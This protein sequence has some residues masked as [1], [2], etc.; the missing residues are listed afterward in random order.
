MATL[1]DNF[2]YERDTQTSYTDNVNNFLRN[3]V[4]GFEHITYLYDLEDLYNK[5]LDLLLEYVSTEEAKESAEKSIEYLENR[6]IKIKE[7]IEQLRNGNLGYAPPAV[8]LRMNTSKCSSA[9]FGINLKYNTLDKVESNILNEDIKYNS[10]NRRLEVLRERLFK[11]YEELVSTYDFTFL[12][13]IVIGTTSLDVPVLSVL[14]RKA[15]NNFKESEYLAEETYKLFLEELEYLIDIYRLTETLSFE[16]LT[17]DKVKELKENRM[18]MKNVKE[19]LE[20]KRDV[21]EHI[22]FITLSQRDTEPVFRS[23]RKYNAS[24]AIMN[25]ASIYLE[26][27]S[28]DE[29]KNFD[30]QTTGLIVEGISSERLSTEE[31]KY[32]K[33]LFKPYAENNYINKK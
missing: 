12:D 14:F 19:V 16:E 33:R 23:K 32:A 11:K 28:K 3:N 8:S 20:I 5:T 29:L 13:K 2:F 10:C 18:K 22:Y 25:Y 17:K 30:I 9:A 21:L 27:H 6:K 15:N 7:E 31:F 26:A 1:L 24:K 4:T